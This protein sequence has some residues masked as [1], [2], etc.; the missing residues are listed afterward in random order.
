MSGDCSNRIKAPE[1]LLV[2]E[3]LTPDDRHAEL[4]MAHRSK[5]VSGVAC[6]VTVVPI[7]HV[8]EALAGVVGG[9]RPLPVLLP[10]EGAEAA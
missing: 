2:K 4:V 5:A 10:Q 7:Q 6:I 3:G 8:S 9:P 1:D